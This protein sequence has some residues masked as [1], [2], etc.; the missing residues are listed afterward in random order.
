LFT[1]VAPRVP[2]PSAVTALPRIVGRVMEFPYSNRTMA[3]PSGTQAWI[4]LRRAALLL[5]DLIFPLYTFGLTRERRRYWQLLPTRRAAKLFVAL[6][7]VLGGVPFFL[8]LL[9]GGTYPLWGILLFAVMLG[10]L[11][12]VT[13]LIELRRPRLMLV[14]ILMIFA[15]FVLFARLPRQERT[16]EFTRR[17]IVMDGAY[18]F[19][20]IMLGYRL[21]LS[22]TTTEGVA[23]VA[24]QT[25]LSFAH[26]LQSTLVPP[27]SYRARGLDIFGCTVPSAK[28]GGDLVDLV[29][30]GDNVLVYLA[31]VSGHGIPAGILMGMLKTAMRQAWLA[32]QPLPA[33]LESVNTVLPAVKEPEMYATLAAL[34]FDASSQV[35]I[36]VAGHP[37]ILHY[38]EKS[39][40]ITRCAMRQYPLG[41]VPE[42]GYASEHVCC[43][44]GDLFV[45]VS[46]GL[47]ETMNAG[48]EEFGLA[49]LEKSVVAHAT[50]SLPAIYEALMRAVS[51]FGEQRDDRTVLIVRIREISKQHSLQPVTVASAPS[52][53][54]GYSL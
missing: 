10:T 19:L 21:F 54:T 40:D 25:E 29:A 5:L 14:P 1:R 3:R 16:L 4:R 12:V 49:R 48:A 35:E 11:R 37:P 28:V 8:D 7:L 20:S 17:R 53:S 36:A 31:D 44:P 41:L 46:D 50:Q 39:R 33:L 51:A 30:G 18:I 43:D 38:R 24:V 23:H 6:F 45:V 15:A 9:A 27:I 32:Q 22:F 2:Q 42:P 13:I 26:G 34:R 52:S 47:I